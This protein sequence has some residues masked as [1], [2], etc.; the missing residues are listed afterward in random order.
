MTWYTESYQNLTLAGSGRR[1]VY[2][3]TY[4]ILYKESRGHSMWAPNSHALL[5]LGKPSK[6]WSL[7]FEPV[8]PHNDCPY[9]PPLCDHI[10]SRV[11][12]QS[13]EHKQVFL[14][15]CRL[16]HLPV[17]LCVRLSG[18]CTAAKLLNGSGCHLGWWVGLVERWVYYMWDC[19]WWSSKGKGQF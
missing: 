9:Q 18:K 3:V 13:I 19:G 5:G 16:D 4:I 1:L 8:T 15:V 10:I 11:A 6:M 2:Q 12:I 7:W 14:H 17:C